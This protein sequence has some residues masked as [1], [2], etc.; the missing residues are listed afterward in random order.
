MA[1]P[2]DSLLPPDQWAYTGRRSALRLQSGAR[3]AACSTMQDMRP[4][5]DGIRF[6]L[7]MKT[8]ND[9]GTRV[10]AMALQQQLRAVG[11]A[12]DVRSFEFATFYS[13]ISH[14]SF[15]MYSLHWAGGNED[16]DIFRYSFASSSFPPHGVNRGDYSNAEVDTVL[17]AAADRVGP[18]ETSQRVCAGAADS[19]EGHT[20]PAALVSRFH[21]DLQPTAQ[22][23]EIFSIRKFLFPGDGDSSCGEIAARHTGS[24]PGAT[25]DGLLGGLEKPASRTVNN[26]AGTRNTVELSTHIITPPAI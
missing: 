7:T 19:G 21:R 12:L 18:G 14:G 9:A 3:E 25:R 4:G 17:Q 15:G 13:D 8:S 6:H 5:K 10:L 22:R 24:V 20:D 2:A 11:I 26:I 23:R 16:P 1:R